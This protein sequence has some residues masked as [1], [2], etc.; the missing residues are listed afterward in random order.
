MARRVRL[1]LSHPMALL[2]AAVMLLPAS[3]GPV[4]IG[5]GRG[6]PA[7]VVMPSG[8]TWQIGPGNR[9]LEVGPDR[10]LR[11]PS[12]A[13]H[14]ARDGNTVLIQPGE[15][16]D[17]A[18]WD[19][20]NLTIAASGPG[21][22]F[23]GKTCQGK[24]IFVINGNDVTVRGITFM[25]AAVPDHNGAGIRAQGT[26]LTIEDS[27][28][29]DNEEGILSG[30]NRRSTIRIIGSEF[31]GNGTCIAACAHGVYAGNIGLL[32]VEQS[33]FTDTHEGH[34]I[35]SRALRTV[36]RG[37]DISDG[38]TG[39]ASYLV[40][41]P[42]GGDLLMEH[43]TLSKGP[44]TDNNT[45]AV[46]IG[47]EGESNP[48]ASLVIRDNAFTNLLSQQTAFVTNRT[49]TPAELSGNRFTGQVTPLV[50]R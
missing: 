27:R 44:H 12:V 6:E 14:Y 4:Q 1:A 5:S 3:C 28:F 22:V 2:L 20:S 37:N 31:R 47:E 35:K 38:P 11:L 16:D 21:V 9:T 36:L 48:T 17:C 15:Y 26:N 32:D 7:L 19:A 23:A 30:A 41:I 10:M 40:D 29:I 42:N 45:T 18:V 49:G 50:G 8:G 24:A 39:H 43:N 46:A 25:H 13:A 34:D 33:H